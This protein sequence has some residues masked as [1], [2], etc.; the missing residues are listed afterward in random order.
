[1]QTPQG[2]H[3][4]DGRFFPDNWWA[5]IFNPSFPYRYL[6]NVFPTGI[7]FMAGIVRRGVT[8]A[9]TTTPHIEAGRPMSP[10]VAST[11]KPA[12]AGE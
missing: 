4:T 1:M 11:P 6:H 3:V 12:P 5:I 8:A 7:A 2:F 10:Y 9:A